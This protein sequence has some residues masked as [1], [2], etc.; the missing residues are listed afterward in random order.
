MRLKDLETSMTSVNRLFGS[1]ITAA[2]RIYFA[3]LRILKLKALATYLK[4]CVDTYRI[5]DVRLINATAVDIFV[6]NL[7]VWTES[8]GDVEDIIKQSN[9]KFDPT[10]FTKFREKW[11]L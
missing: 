11:R 5:P 4:K 9:I 2:R 8:S 10:K 1:N 3:P 6:Q 7:D